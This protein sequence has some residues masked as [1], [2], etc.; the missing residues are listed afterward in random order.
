[1]NHLFSDHLMGKAALWRIL[2]GLIMIAA[3]YVLPLFGLG[4]AL[5]AFFPN[6]GPSALLG[7]EPLHLVVLLSTFIPVWFGVRLAMAWP[8]GAPIQALYSAALRINWRDFAIGASIALIVASITEIGLSAALF[9]DDFTYDAYL[10]NDTRT[11]LAFLGPFLI[12][13]LFQAGAEEV[14]F[15]GYILRLSWAR[16]GRFW[17]A[18]FIPSFIFGLGHFSPSEFGG[19]AWFYVLNTTVSG[20]I[21]CA[22]TVFRGNLGAAFGLHF[23]VNA[24]GMLI[25][26]NKGYLSGGA[27]F[28]NSTA[29]DDGVT[30]LAMLALTLIEVVLYTVWA[31]RVYGRILPRF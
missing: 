6:L 21:L 8:I 13:I 11:W 20:V 3:I 4:F 26:S 31:Y 9:G 1:M 15:R 30:G 29:L 28:L 27:L 19:N 24:F 25:L 14:L 16:G 10:I 2:V 12:L 17:W 23:G 18:I 5:A 7:Q 22:I